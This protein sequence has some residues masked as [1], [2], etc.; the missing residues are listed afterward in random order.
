MSDLRARAPLPLRRT[1]I[2]A[3]IAHAAMLAALAVALPAEI[4]GAQD[5]V[6][7]TQ[8]VAARSDDF[9]G[10]SVATDG[11]R[12][13]AG[14]PEHDLPTVGG[15]GAIAIFE[16]SRG[17][18]GDGWTRTALLMASDAATADVL[19]EWIAIDGDLLIASAANV[20]LLTP[21]PWTGAA[22]VF[23]RTAAGW[24]QR[25]KLLPANPN[26]FMEAGLASA[27]DA[28]T[29]TAVL[30]ARLDDDVATDAGSVGVFRE[31]GGA[32][33]LVEE[34]HAPD[35]A[36]GDAFGF[37]VAIDGD[38]L[39]VATPATDAVAE[40]TGSVYVF[41]RGKRGFEF[42]AKLMAADAAYRDRFGSSVDVEG[43]TIVVGAVGDDNLPPGGD[44]GAAYVFRRVAGSW[45]QEA[46]LVAADRQPLDAFGTSVAIDGGRVVIG[47]AGAASN[48]GAVYL[49]EL[50]GGAWTETA[51]FT[52][53]TSNAND[54]LGASVALRGPL[55]V[56]GAPEHDF[57]LANAGAFSVA[58]LAA[59]CPADLDDDGEVGASDLSLL[60]LAWGSLGAG[61]PADLDGDGAVGAADLSLLLESWG[62]AGTSCG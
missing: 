9:L 11:V 35:A 16:R 1:A 28:E 55:L 53:P 57:P 22:Y 37:R 58:T 38:V 50:A 5:L 3:G 40:S 43:E 52:S 45:T 6:R 29:R 13:A 17:A 51:K 24:T 32:W 12:I 18:S 49:F 4:A 19:G 27:I 44:Q 61:L 14:V 62:P 26:E 23:E 48:Q 46:K 47:A 56:A 15:A 21:A 34:L 30:P 54:R 41:E 59:S 8:G 42:R 10:R 36:P 31:I 60:L 25:A 20:G 7:V 33:T 2:A 39:A